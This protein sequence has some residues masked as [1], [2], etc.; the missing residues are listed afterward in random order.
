MPS[1]TAVNRPSVTVVTSV[2]P[3]IDMPSITAV[4]RRR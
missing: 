2:S 4:N 1:I 3:E